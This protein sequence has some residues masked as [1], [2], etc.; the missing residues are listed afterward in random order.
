MAAIELAGLTKEFAGGIQALSDL[1]LNVPAGEC[2]VLAGPSGCGKTTTLRLIAG[3]E[4][5]TAGTIHLG[6]RS[7][8]GIPPSRR[9]VAMVFQR[10]ALFP[11]RTVRQNLTLGLA[12]R[13]G[14][15]RKPSV[16]Q[17]RRMTEIA[18]VLGLDDV[19]ERYPPH[20]SGGQ[21]HRVALGR[22]LLRQAPVLLLDE[23][24]GHLDAPLR[25][26]LRRQLILLRRRFP[27]TIIHVTH[28]AAE[29][30]ALGDRLAILDDGQLL[31]TGTAQELLARPAHR[32][33]ARFLQD[34]SVVRGKLHRENG[35]WHFSAGDARWDIPRI[36]WFGE[37]PPLEVE[38][39]I[40]GPQVTVSHAGEATCL[41]DVE[42][43]E[44]DAS[45]Q[46][47]IGR[48]GEATLTARCDPTLQVR[49]GQRVMMSWNW[50]NTW[51]FNLEGRTVG[52][53]PAT[54]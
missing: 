20:L 6:G 16:E 8:Q 3:L 47:V 19:L 11:N 52:Q 33:V 12:Q 39:G 29:A 15:F 21:Q 9:P 14:W 45:G 2:L 4:T 23:P 30:L 36:Q 25:L 49:A 54:A 7:V 24:L 51:I 53:M 32:F 46:R 38:L 50:T 41:M 43:V 18:D 28:D 42:L 27:A 1:S 40:R 13:L 34:V 48:H 22:A 10:P 31:Q 26:D 35:Q 37:P 44:A 5:P 17:A